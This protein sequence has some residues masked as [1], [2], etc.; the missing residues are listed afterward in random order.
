MDNKPKM[1]QNKTSKIFHNNREVYTSYDKKS[2]TDDNNVFINNNIRNKINN[3]VNS[4]NF[5]YSKMVH[6]V[7]DNEVILRKIVGVYG[8]NVVTIDNEYIPINNI[9]DIYV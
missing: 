4:N 5:I 7:I 8:D 2:N 1:Y 6:I 3:I 9:K